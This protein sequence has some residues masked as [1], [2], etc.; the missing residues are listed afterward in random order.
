MKLTLAKVISLTLN[1]LCI[2]VFLPFILVY[3][4]THNFASAYHWLL[5]TLIFLA[6]LT[7]I[8]FIGVKQ[9]RFTDMDVSKREQRPLLFLLCSVMGIIYLI[10][11]H[12]FHAPF[13]LFVVTWGILLGIIA[14]SI[15]NRK[16]KASMHVATMTAILLTVSFGYGGYF[17]LLLLLLPLLAWARL[18]TKRHTLSEV[19]AGGVIGSVL[20][21]SVYG[22][23]I[24][25]KL[26]L[27][28]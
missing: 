12:I 3:K 1:P 8:V 14:V 15:I 17:Y 9:K 27:H 19:I 18:K 26:L 21:L 23:Y 25:V 16:I 6:L 22:A 28:K 13:V 10:G 5:Y 24:A 2:I 7:L 4:S 11:L 20:S